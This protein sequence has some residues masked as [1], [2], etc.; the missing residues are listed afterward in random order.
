MNKYLLIRNEIGVL[1]LVVL[2]RFCNGHNSIQ[3][4]DDRELNEFL[5]EEYRKNPN[6]NLTVVNYS[7]DERNYKHVRIPILSLKQGD[8]YFVH[9]QENIMYIEAAGS[10]SIIGIVNEYPI[11][12]T[13][14]LAEIEAKLSKEIFV[15][16]H[17]SVIVNINYITKFVGNVVFAGNKTFPVGRKFKYPFMSRL[18]LLGNSNR[19]F[20]AE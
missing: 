2:D 12:V 20:R 16:I 11:T 3:V 4:L 14:N 8:Y 5:K 17:R 18:N 9:R 7:F 13:F 6:L 15:R 10:Y 19:L 1:S